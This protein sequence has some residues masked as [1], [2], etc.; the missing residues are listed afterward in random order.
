MLPEVE[1]LMLRL[2]TPD[3]V[4]LAGHM[5][6]QHIHSGG[7]RFRAGLALSAC[8]ALGVELEA[9]VPW[10]AAVEMLHN[11]SLVHDDIQDGDHTRRGRPTL[12]ATHG[13]PQAI[14]AGDLMLML[15]FQALAHLRVH[16]AVQ[17]ALTQALVES[18]CRLVRGQVEDIAM[19]SNL[20][21][22]QGRWDE[23]A[24]SK[25]GELFALPVEGAALLAGLSKTQAQRLSAPFVELGLAFQ[26][27]DDLIDLY[28]D[29]GRE[30]P[31]GDLREGKVSA[32]V[33]EHL[34]RVPADRDQLLDLLRLPRELS[35]QAEVERS[36]EAFRRSGA[37][38]AV[39]GRALLV[40]EGASQ[41]PLLTGRPALQRLADGL[42]ARIATPLLTLLES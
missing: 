16:P 29:K 13:V 32:L 33:L 11:A 36:I 37:A 15:P 14:N 25:T 20:E 1:S 22:D 10:A 6:R 5:V 34:S 3:R 39:V 30:L 40:L 4:D 24:R 18:A 8:A 9:A 21:L 7:R 26:L 19:N 38:E 41:S 31:G 2:A 28:G 27:Q 12:W 23:V 42:A 35:P 17:V